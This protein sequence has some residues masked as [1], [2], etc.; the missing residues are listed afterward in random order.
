MKRVCWL[1]LIVPEIALV[2]T[3]PPWLGAAPSGMLASKTCAVVP[4]R[5]RTSTKYESAGVILTST[6]WTRSAVASSLSPCATT[7]ISVLVALRSH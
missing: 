5:C 3:T 7:S 1:L 2:T 6:T 4:G